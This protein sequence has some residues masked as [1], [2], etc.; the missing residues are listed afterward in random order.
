MDRD[1]SYHP[2][3][4]RKKVSRCSHTHTQKRGG[5]RRCSIWLVHNAKAT[6]AFNTDILWTTAVD[7][8]D[9]LPAEKY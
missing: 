1:C 2:G 3:K 6:S 4:K 7:L 5:R 9:A 8:G